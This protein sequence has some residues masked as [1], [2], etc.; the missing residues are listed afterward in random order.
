MPEDYMSM[1]R[2]LPDEQAKAK[3]PAVG[4]A[5]VDMS[6]TTGP[7]K[8]LASGILYGIPD[9]PDQIPDHFYKDIGFNY[10][11]GGGS[12]LPN[13]KGYAVSFED[14]KAR[15]NSGLSNYITA[16]KHG[17][18]FIYLLPAAWGADGGQ[19]E[20]FEYPGDNGDWTRWDAFLEQTLKDVQDSEMKDGLVI[21]I[22]NEPDLSFFWGASKE[23]WLA[24]WSRTFKKVKKTLPSVRIAGPSISAIPTTG[25]DWWTD[26]LTECIKNDTL[27]DQWSW[28]MESGN[29]C[30]TMAGSMKSFHDLLAKFD[31]P[32][33]KAKDVNINEYAVY[34]EQ[35]PSAGAWWIAGLERENAHGLR[36]NWAIAGALHDFLAGLLCKPNATNENYAI[37]GEGYWPTAEYQVY[38]YY[39]SKMTGQ[40]VKTTPTP[41][42]FLDVYATV[43]DNAVRILA[44][45]RSRSGDWTIELTGL[46]E[47]EKVDI[48]TLAFVVKGSDKFNN[49]DGPEHLSDTTDHVKNGCLRL[50]MKHEDN[51]TAYAFEVTL[52]KRQ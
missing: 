20:N 18:E 39:G 42:S 45:T 48:R 1:L 10:G 34:G 8:H 7:P 3:G 24:L 44:G 15:F 4:V 2:G 23:Q 17:G 6:I 37:E 11:R 30:D 40:R 26:F 46:P 13:T 33:E 49:V 52:P 32:L 38:K 47:D 9:K 41:D 28:H 25:H 21:D 5:T 14:Y 51:T 27:P 43:D 29:D 12:Q 16:R 36:G 19:S 50:K 35:V 22:W 31:V